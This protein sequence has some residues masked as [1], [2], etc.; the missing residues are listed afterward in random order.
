M[1]KSKLKKDFLEFVGY[2][3]KMA[4]INDEHCH[5]EENKKTGDSGMKNNGKSSDAGSRSSG[6]KS[7]ESSHGGASVIDVLGRDNKAEG[8]YALFRTCGDP[9]T[10]QSQPYLLTVVN[11]L[12]DI[13]WSSSRTSTFPA[14]PLS[15]DISCFIINSTRVASLVAVLSLGLMYMVGVATLFHWCENKPASTSTTKGSVAPTHHSRG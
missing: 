11:L 13:I 14:T 12:H 15:L 5:V 7:G 3:K 10:S 9:S 8:L 1:D 2:L 4:I 6:H